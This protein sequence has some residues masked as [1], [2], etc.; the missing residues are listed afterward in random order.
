MKIVVCTNGINDWYREVVKYGLRNLEEYCKLH[1]YKCI[2]NTEDNQDIY[3]G[4]RECPWYKI[5][6]IKKILK[7]EDCDYVVW[8]DAD[9]QI[10][11][12]EQKLEYFIQ[13]FVVDKDVDLALVQERPLNTGVLFIR[14]CEF[15]LKLMD[16][17]WNNKNDFDPALHEQASLAEIYIRDDEVKKHIHIIPYCI[18]DELVVYWGSYYPNK[19][20]LLHSARCNFDRISLM[21]MMDTYYMF[22]MDEETEEQYNERM[23]YVKTEK[24]RKDLDSWLHNPKANVERKYSQRCIQYIS[25]NHPFFHKK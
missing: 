22:K 23:D 9:I 14:N 12:Q 8:L 20:F 2:I 16:D 17:I 24:I 6:T 10:L 4:K 21:F 5:K 19:S 7:T 13:K 3:D 1:N 11:K 18:Q 25:G 15:N